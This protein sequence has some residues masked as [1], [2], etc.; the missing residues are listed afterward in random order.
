[1]REE[2]AAVIGEAQRDTVCQNDWDAKSAEDLDGFGN[3]REETEKEGQA[4]GF[5]DFGDPDKSKE[6]GFDL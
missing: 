6:E 3:F 4:E 2:V 1:M 5:G